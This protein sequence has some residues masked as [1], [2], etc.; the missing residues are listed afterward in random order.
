MNKLKLAIVGCGDIAGFTALVQRLV[1]Q[2]TL[3][4]CCDVNAERAQG[5]AK[6]HRIPQVFTDYNELLA[7]SSADAVYLA[8][9]HHLHYEMILAA[10]NAGKPVFVEKPITRTLS[11]G[12]K[13][14]RR[15]CRHKG[16]RELPVSLRQRML[17]AG[18][19]S[20]IWRA[21]KSPF[22]A[23]QHSLASHAEVISMARP[24]TRPSRRRAAGR[25]SRRA[26]TFW[27]W[28]CGH[29]ARLPSRQWAM[30]NDSAFR[31]G[32]G[33]TG[34]RHRRNGG[35]TLISVVSSM[36]AATEQKVTIEAYGE[37]GTALY[38]DR[39]LPHVK[40]V[41]VKIHK[42]RPPEWGVHALQRSL[43]G[44]RKLDFE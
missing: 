20:A 6:R 22:H 35:G 1:P 38:A 27:M 19:G 9:P 26:V 32:S 24:G 15:N 39:P 8:V 29:W 4:A 25:S 40:F 21:G 16:R 28:R 13:T 31:C 37:R 2:V 7:K 12:N 11:E 30:R 17:R 43:T 42:E 34:A 36:V 41:G 3:S 23:H 18:A 44:I 33:H 10:V 5:F 14:H